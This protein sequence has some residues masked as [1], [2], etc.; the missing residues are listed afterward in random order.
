MYFSTGNSQH[1]DL[2]KDIR[3]RVWQ[4]FAGGRLSG[5]MGPRPRTRISAH[6]SQSAVLSNRPG[7]T[8]G[9]SRMWALGG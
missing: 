4:Q 1:N 9:T 5:S 6:A 3:E 7:A 2:A 8:T